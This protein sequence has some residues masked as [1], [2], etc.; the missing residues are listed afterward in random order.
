[1]AVNIAKKVCGRNEVRG[2]IPLSG[3]NVR[4]WCKP[5]RSL[6]FLDHEISKECLAFLHKFAISRVGL[7]Y[8]MKIYMMVQMPACTKGE[9]ETK[10]ISIVNGT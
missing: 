10:Y 1:M 9:C 8:M 5:Y 4:L 6:S 2:L 7:R 3:S